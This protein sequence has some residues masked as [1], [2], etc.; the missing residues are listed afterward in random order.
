MR[1]LFVV[2]I[3]HSTI[4]NWEKGG[5]HGT[6]AASVFEAEKATVIGGVAR[7]RGGAVAWWR[8]GVVAWWRHWWCHWWVSGV[9]LC[10]SR[11]A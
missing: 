4:N 2:I 8:G 11:H 6:K 1:S 9:P 7:W 5:K 3:I 10:K